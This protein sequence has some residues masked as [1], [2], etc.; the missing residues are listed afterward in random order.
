MKRRLRHLDSIQP[1]APA[2]LVIRAIAAR[3]ISQSREITPGVVPTPGPQQQHEKQGCKMRS[4][5]L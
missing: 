5:R 3:A 2:V 1:F 4:E